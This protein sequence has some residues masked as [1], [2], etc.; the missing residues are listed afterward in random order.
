MNKHNNHPAQIAF[1]AARDAMNVIDHK[2]DAMD[3]TE[4]CLVEFEAIE[5]EWDRLA[6][7]EYQ[8]G[9]ELIRWAWSVLQSAPGA[10]EARP[11]V[12]AALAGRPAARLRFIKLAERMSA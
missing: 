4:E 6:A 10:E 5:A 7:L 1:R 2:L 12:E 9:T 11:A 3:P 8:A